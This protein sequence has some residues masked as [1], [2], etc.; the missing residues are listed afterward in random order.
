MYLFYQKNSSKYLIQ[1][2]I[3]V[4]LCESILRVQCNPLQVLVDASVHA[5]VVRLTAA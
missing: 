5:G 4:N 1:Q 2:I 3:I